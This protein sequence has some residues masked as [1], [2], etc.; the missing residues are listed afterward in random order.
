MPRTVKVAIVGSGLAGLTAA[1]LLGHCPPKNDIE[2]EV[3]LF[4]KVSAQSYVILV[5]FFTDF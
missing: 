4:E 2:F 3:H 5:S 1:H